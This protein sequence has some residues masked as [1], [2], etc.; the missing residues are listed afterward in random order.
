MTASYSWANAGR[1]EGNSNKRQKPEIRPRVTGINVTSPHTALENIN[2]TIYG[3]HVRTFLKDRITPA[4]M[5]TWGTSRHL[6]FK[7]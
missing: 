1:T 2:S 3:T 5:K 4:G 6:G 7:K